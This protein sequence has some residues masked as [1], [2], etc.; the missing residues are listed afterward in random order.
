MK[1]LILTYPDDLAQ[2]IH[3][4]PDEL[5]AQVRLMASLK[6]F[7]LGCLMMSRSPRPFIAN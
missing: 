7:E 2:A 5:A 4:T 1:E 6:M 3:L